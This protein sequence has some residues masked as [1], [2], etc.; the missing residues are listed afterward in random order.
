VESGPKRTSSARRER[1]RATILRLLGAHELRRAAD[2]AHEHLAEFP[3]EPTL[4]R[5]VTKALFGSTD[6]A[7]RC[8]ADEFPI[9]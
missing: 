4:R 6:P 3:D 7:L 2:L 1:Q 8:R 5:A 9:D